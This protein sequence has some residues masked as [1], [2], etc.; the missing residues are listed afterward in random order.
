MGEWISGVRLPSFRLSTPPAL[1]KGFGNEYP[2]LSGMQRILSPAAHVA[3]SRSLLWYAKEVVPRVVEENLGAIVYAGGDDVLAF[4][5]P[6]RAFTVAQRLSEEFMREWDNRSGRIV[7][8]M[9]HRA[10]CSAGLILAHYM[11]PLTHAISQTRSLQEDAKNLE[12]G[13]HG[14]GA[15]KVDF[16]GRAGPIAMMSKALHWINP[17]DG[18]NLDA[19]KEYVTPFCKDSVTWVGVS[20]FTSGY[21]LVNE[22]FGKSKPRFFSPLILA[23]QFGAISRGG[24][25]KL[26]DM[27]VGRRCFYE[28]IKHLADLEDFELHPLMALIRLTLS[29]HIRQR[30]K[31]PQIAELTSRRLEELGELAKIKSTIEASIVAEHAHEFSL[32]SLER[33]KVVS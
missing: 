4:I 25:E 11:Y 20:V 12:E 24:V 6:E 15:V 18:K 26:K 21:D 30:E 10:S 27:E 33:F 23:D 22:V 9:G 17:W 19:L 16:Y 2:N 5:P 14:K 28:L 13:V 3:I 7:I 32:S 1:R 29:R 8:G 31:L